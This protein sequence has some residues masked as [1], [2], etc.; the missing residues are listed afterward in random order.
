[1]PDGR[2]DGRQARGGNRC[3]QRS[4]LQRLL[5]RERAPALL[6]LS[7]GEGACSAS[8]L[9][10]LLHTQQRPALLPAPPP[11]SILKYTLICSTNDSNTEV[12]LHG[13]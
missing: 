13:R 10:F 12:T 5:A 6:P 7:A 3:T 1:M 9:L 8:S 2:T 11:P 4:C